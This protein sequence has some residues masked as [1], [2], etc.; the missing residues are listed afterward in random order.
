MSSSSDLSFGAAYGGA[1]AA[2]DPVLALSK[3]G[4]IQAPGAYT[5]SQPP[6]TSTPMG[7]GTGKPAG[8][9][10]PPGAQI[11]RLSDDDVVRIALAV[12][13]LINLDVEQLNTKYNNLVQCC[14][15][16]VAENKRMSQKLD[17]LEMY[18]RRSCIRIFGVPESEADTNRAVLDI[19]KELQVNVDPSDLVVSH[20]VG[21]PPR[22]KDTKPRAII[23]RITNYTARHELLRQSKKLQKNPNRRG[24]YINQDLT[25]T[26]NKLAYHSR[27]IAKLGKAKSS[28]VWDGKIFIVDHADRKHL[29]STLDD[30]ID[31]KNNLCPDYVIP[32]DPREVAYNLPDNME[33]DP[34]K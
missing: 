16:L 27:Q 30:L 28:F 11:P 29:I 7:T 17:D 1:G 24:V 25:K 32:S 22:P 6:P 23:A 26:R 3:L 20:R 13:T 18:S 34:P 2:M 19:A 14:N 31:V 9:V 15:Q 33:Q 21:P 12:K 8:H 5:L 10:L 4:I